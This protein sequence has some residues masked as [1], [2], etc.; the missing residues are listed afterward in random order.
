MDV[1]TDISKSGLGDKAMCVAGSESLQADPDGMNHKAVKVIK[2]KLIWRPQEVR[3]ER[4]MEH[5]RKL[6]AAS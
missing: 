6:Q 4:N 3:N 5:L 1:S 2:P